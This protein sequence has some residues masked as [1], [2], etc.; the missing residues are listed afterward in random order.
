[1]EL[2]KKD[3]GLGLKNTMN[4]N[5][6]LLVSQAWRIFSYDSSLIKKPYIAKYKKDPLT[7]SLSNS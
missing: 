5:K 1:M 4:M 7:A 3:G 2:H 6:T